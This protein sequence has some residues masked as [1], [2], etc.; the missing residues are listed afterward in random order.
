MTNRQPL[1]FTDPRDNV[2]AFAKMWGSFAP[3]P[4]IAT[5]HGTMFASIGTDRLLPVFGFAG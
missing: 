2:Y 3:E 4:H 5:F 1:D